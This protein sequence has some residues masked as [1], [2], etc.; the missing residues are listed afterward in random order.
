VFDLGHTQERFLAAGRESNSLFLLKLTAAIMWEHFPTAGKAQA[1]ASLT[2]LNA[3]KH[4]A[5]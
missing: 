4:A 3:S 1:S 2:N 5:M